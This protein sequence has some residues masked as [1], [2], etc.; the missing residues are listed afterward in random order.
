MQHNNLYMA[1]T[2]SIHNKENNPVVSSKLPSSDQTNESSTTGMSSSSHSTTTPG[3][4]G[5]D[6]IIHE[7]LSN[8]Y[9]QLITVTKDLSS[10]Y[11]DTLVTL[12]DGDR[13]SNTTNNGDEEKEQR[14]NNGG[15]GSTEGG[16]SS[17]SS[18]ISPSSSSITTPIPSSVS[19]TP[20]I[21]V[22][23]TVGN[24]V[25]HLRH[26]PCDMECPIC[27]EVYP[28]ESCVLLACGDIFC[29]N[30]IQQHAYTQYLN[31][32]RY[33]IPCPSSGSLPMDNNNED[34]QGSRNNSPSPPEE[35]E[36]YGCHSYLTP[37]EIQH[38]LTPS[39]YKTFE[40]RGLESLCVLNNNFK[41]C[42]VPDCTYIVA[43]NS[44]DTSIIT[45]LDCP[46]CKTISCLKCKK[47]PYDSHHTCGNSSSNSSS[48]PKNQGTDSN[49]P[50]T[51]NTNNVTQ[52]QAPLAP[53]RTTGNNRIPR[54]ERINM[55]PRENV[56]SSASASFDYF[57]ELMEKRNPDFFTSDDDDDDENSPLDFHL[58]SQ[59]FSEPA[60]NSGSTLT[61]NS[62]TQ[63]VLP[64]TSPTSV[65]A[66]VPVVSTTTST[67]TGTTSNPTS[68]AL[69]ATVDA[70]AQQI[71][72]TM[73]IK[74]CRR[75]G[76]GVVKEVG[77][78]KLKCRCGYRFCWVCESE[79]AQ[80]GCTPSYHGFHD[81]VAGYAIFDNLQAKQSPT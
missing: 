16:K 52:L 9:E 57:I 74:L 47:Y 48:I 32:A 15:M 65:R 63:G 36:S 35:E 6:G 17:S 73:G 31:G 26:P 23:A 75:C 41:A 42:P 68:T 37:I 28:P 20:T 58:A 33:R 72:N 5:G 19:A 38:L 59:Y 49:Y 11:M 27:M 10:S 2:N 18:S 29:S 1:S 66:T 3:G 21:T 70:D 79:N 46:V 44:Q 14:V 39:Q 12:N 43:V 8:L 61:T 34:N 24:G 67:T 22:T 13:S 69:I 51:T 81:N 7:F 80:C 78:H 4:P 71:L 55:D 25:H 40:Y 30:C 45:R 76:Q 50:R 56:N 54:H 64:S 62:G 60:D 53:Y 77:C